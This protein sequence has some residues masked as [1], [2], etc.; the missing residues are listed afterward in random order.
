MLIHHGNKLIPGVLTGEYI[1]KRLL[2]PDI[3]GELDVIPENAF[4][5]HVSPR[6]KL[7][8]EQETNQTC[9]VFGDTKNALQQLLEAIGR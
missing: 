5:L 7:L 9:I 1:A 8:H 6:Q 2:Q 4:F 3:S